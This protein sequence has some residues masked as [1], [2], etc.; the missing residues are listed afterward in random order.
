MFTVYTKYDKNV[1]TTAMEDLSFKLEETL[2]KEAP[3]RGFKD[4]FNIGDQMLGL[5][6][7]SKRNFYMP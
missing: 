1:K 5:K 6:N 2:Y 3:D 7:G 4:S